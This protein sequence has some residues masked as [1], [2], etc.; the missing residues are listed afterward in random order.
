[1]YVNRGLQAGLAAPALHDNNIQYYIGD[2]FESDKNILNFFMSDAAAADNR[3]E[4]V[5]M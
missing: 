3:N 5:M 2:G 1:V 4:L